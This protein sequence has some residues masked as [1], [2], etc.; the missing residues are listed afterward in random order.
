MSNK[1]FRT[2]E[3]GALLIV[4]LVSV[5]HTRRVTTLEIRY[6]TRVAELEEKLQHLQEFSERKE[7]LEQNLQTALTTIEQERQSFEQV[8]DCSDSLQ[9]AT[10]IADIGLL[11]NPSC[12]RTWREKSYRR[13][14]DCVRSTKKRYLNECTTRDMLVAHHCACSTRSS[15][16]RS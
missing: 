4:R 5:R 9:T 15:P 10:F 11:N 3:K 12:Q 7:E 13:G 8:C 6:K 14:T 16:K 1:A 2:R